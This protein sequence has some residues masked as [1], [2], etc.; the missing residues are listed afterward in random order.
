MTNGIIKPAS[1]GTNFNFA[2]T[3][4]IFSS[5]IGWLTLRGV[6]LIDSIVA[7]LITP[8]SVACS[9]GERNKNQNVAAWITGTISISRSVSRGVTPSAIR[10]AQL[11]EPIIPAEPV[12]LDHAVMHFLNDQEIIFIRFRNEENHTVRD[13]YLLNPAE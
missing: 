12:P 5:L 8:P 6:Q 13:N 7:I 2:L 4:L 9:L 1:F 3:P 10:P 11:I